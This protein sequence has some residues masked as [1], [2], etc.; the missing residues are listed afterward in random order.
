MQQ[1]LCA[2]L[3]LSYSA[4]INYIIDRGCLSL[5]PGMNIYCRFTI[6]PFEIFFF[7]GPETYFDG[8]KEY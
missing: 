3:I 7:A 8:L 2:D 6:N 4:D 1:A 5:A